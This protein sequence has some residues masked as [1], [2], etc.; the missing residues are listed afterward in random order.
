G[1]T[2]ELW[3]IEAGHES[4][5]FEAFQ[6]RVAEQCGAARCRA[7]RMRAGS[8]HRTLPLARAAVRGPMIRGPTPLARKPLQTYVDA[9]RCQICYQTWLECCRRMS[10]W[11][12]K[13][14]LII[15]GSKGLGLAIAR[16]CVT[17]GAHVV[18]TA[19]N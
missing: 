17:A 7:R 3:H 6:P 2:A 11:H 14:A 8:E 12:N 16:A 9:S 18:I 5:V 13:V 4:A 1:P 19:R 15:G 10:F